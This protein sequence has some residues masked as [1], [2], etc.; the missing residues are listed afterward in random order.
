MSSKK[1]RV[2]FELD[3]GDVKNLKDEEIKTILRAADGIISTGGRNMLAKI[4]KGSKDKKVLEHGM[5]QCPVYGYFRD[6]TLPEIT[7]RVDWMIK[8]S[9]LEIEYSDRLPMLVFTEKG[10]EIER[11]TYAE[12][13]LVKLIDLVEGEDYSFVQELKDRNRGMILL[14]TEKIKKTGNAGFI[15]LL[16]AWKEIEYKKVQVEI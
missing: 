9:Y 3:S 10:W 13:L 11:E 1:A 8:N 5:D 14:L 6:L 7:N 2:R 4:L 15:P 12:E 16:K